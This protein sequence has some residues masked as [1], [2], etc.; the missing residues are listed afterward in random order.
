M[1]TVVARWLGAELFGNLLVTWETG[2]PEIVVDFD[3]PSA[4]FE[5]I[6]RNAG[7]EL[8]GLMSKR[9]RPVSLNGKLHLHQNQLADWCSRLA[10]FG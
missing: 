8:T 7:V 5:E 9:L 1:P 6:L 10:K 2:E 4:N 3:G